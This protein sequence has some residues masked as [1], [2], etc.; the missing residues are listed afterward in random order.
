MGEAEHDK[1]K[2]GQR[3]GLNECSRAG[4]TSLL[5]LVFSVIITI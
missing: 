2:F 4:S 3:L 5:N 1:K